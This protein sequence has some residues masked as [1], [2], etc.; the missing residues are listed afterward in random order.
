MRNKNTESRDRLTARMVR[1][2]AREVGIPELLEESQI[3]WRI[4]PHDEVSETCVQSEELMASAARSSRDALNVM[5]RMS[6]DADV[7]DK[8]LM[9]ALKKYVQ[10]TCEAIKQVDNKLKDE[11]SG[12]EKLLFEVSGRSQNGVAWRDLIGRRDVIAHRLLTIDDERVRR[13]AERDFDSLH[14]L[15]SR[16]YF[17]P[18]K[19]DLGDGKGFSPM[20]KADALRRLEPSVGGEKPRVGAALVFI[21]EDKKEGFLAFRLGRTKDDKILMSPSRAGTL[22]LSISFV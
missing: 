13:E 21:V 9:T 3:V 12:L 5:E 10:D 1:H 11:K 6:R 16:V 20:L 19:T 18:V 17:A 8:D 14:E 4:R 22:P 15:V 7:S 2:G